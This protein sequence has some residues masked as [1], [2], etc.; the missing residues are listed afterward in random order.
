MTLCVD[1][2]NTSICLGVFEQGSLRFKARLASDCKKSADEYA[3]LL[4]GIFSM[5]GID[6]SEISDAAMLSVV[7]ALTHTLTRALA[8]FGTEPLVIGSGIKTGLNLRIES[9]EL[10]G[11]DI[12][13]DT[14]AAL[15][16]AKPPLIVLD[17]GTATTIS[18][19]NSAGE[20]T[21]CVI[22]PGVKLSLEALSE[23]CALLPEVPLS[24]PTRTVGK[25]TAEAIN[26]GAVLGTTLMLDGY[27]ERIKR[28]NQLETLTVIA[29]GGL[30]ELILPLSE[31]EMR[32]E[33]YLTLKGLLFLSELNRSAR[34]RRAP[35]RF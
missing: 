24:A 2:G 11:A 12:V 8:A 28:E 5:K 17:L 23:K 9:P 6:P 32:Y 35:Q 25:N 15:R 22:A 13:A 10:L 7:P 19:V 4:A 14:V 26:S 20:L 21:G 31:N 34:A 3:V 30:A 18:V 29:T 1:I 33:P 27:I 16:L